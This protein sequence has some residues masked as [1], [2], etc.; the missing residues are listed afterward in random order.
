MTSKY[1]VAATQ[2]I[3]PLTESVLR[4]EHS[5]IN[6]KKKHLTVLGERHY[7]KSMTPRKFELQLKSRKIDFYTFEIV[8]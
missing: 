8:T 3:G 1:T 2:S 6:S 4:I 5:S 7:G